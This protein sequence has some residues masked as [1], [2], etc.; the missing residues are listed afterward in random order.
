MKY[1]NETH[2]LREDKN[3]HYMKLEVTLWVFSCHYPGIGFC[4]DKRPQ[5][6]LISKWFLSGIDY[7]K[8]QSGGYLE[9]NIFSNCIINLLL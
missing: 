5:P 9:A 2:E 7:E 8:Q 4:L 6:N 3:L 1:E